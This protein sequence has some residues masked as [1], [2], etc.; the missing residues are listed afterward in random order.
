MA[1][2]VI[3]D[4]YS[5]REDQAVRRDPA[6]LGLAAEIALGGRIRSKQP[7]NAVHFR[8]P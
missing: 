8:A 4:R 3:G 2:E 6:P 1:R 7:K 5:R